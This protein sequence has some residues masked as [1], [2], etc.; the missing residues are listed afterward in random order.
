MLFR[1]GLVFN[2][3]ADYTYNQSNNDPTTRAPGGPDTTPDMTIVG[4]DVLTLEKTGPAT[5]QVGTP[6]S[7]TLNVHNPSSGIAWNPILTDRLPDGATGGTCGA[8]PSNVTAQF[9]EA[10][11]VTPASGVLEEG[12]DY[13]VSFNGA[14]TCEWNISLL[15]AAGGLA[16]DQ[17]L[18]V[19]YD[20]EL[21]P[22]TDNGS[23]LTNVAGVT[24]WFSADPGVADAAPRTYTRELTDE[25][26]RA[27][28]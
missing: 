12:T 15:S 1:S 2:N 28:V 13:Q 4:P 7:F 6:G 19:R 5:M 21:D 23:A 24:Q 22:S 20:V 27:H 3:T 26:G 9:F 10:D 17:R 11:G 14:P 8:G 18:I 16:P 25:I